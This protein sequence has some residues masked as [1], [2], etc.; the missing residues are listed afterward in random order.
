[1]NLLTSGGNWLL[2]L[3]QVIQIIVTEFTVFNLKKA[4]TTEFENISAIMLI[5]AVIRI[6]PSEDC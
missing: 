6:R 5:T 3:I 4:F 1:M 2:I